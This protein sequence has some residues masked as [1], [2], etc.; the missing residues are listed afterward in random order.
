M[1]ASKKPTT[2]KPAARSSAHSPAS[3]STATRRDVERQIARFDKAL[4][5]FPWVG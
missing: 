3:G 4:L 5:L 2:R 1:P